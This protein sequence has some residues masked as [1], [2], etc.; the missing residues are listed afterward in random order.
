MKLITHFHPGAEIIKW[1]ELYVHSPNSCRGAQLKNME[2]T[3]LSPLPSFH[4]R[5]NVLITFGTILVDHDEDSSNTN[6]MRILRFSWRWCFKSRFP[7]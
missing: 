1:V 5:I 6:L 2:T 4:C 3:L 7:G